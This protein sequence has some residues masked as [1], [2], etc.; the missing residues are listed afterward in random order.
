MLQDRLVNALKHG[1]AESH[2]DAFD[3]I[4]RDVG[5]TQLIE[6][7]FPEEASVAVLRARPRRYLAIPATWLMRHSQHVVAHGA[8]RRLDGAGGLR[9]R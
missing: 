3:P 4:E 9:I 1:F 7:S 2:P 8:Y 6:A 5:R